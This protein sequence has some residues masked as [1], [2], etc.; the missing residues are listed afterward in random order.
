MAFNLSKQLLKVILRK[1]TLNRRQKINL[2]YKDNTIPKHYFS[3]E[4]QKR[5][6]YRIKVFKSLLKNDFQSYLTSLQ[7]YTKKQH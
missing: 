5:C 1:T 7:N 6:K 3:I 2:M 4:T